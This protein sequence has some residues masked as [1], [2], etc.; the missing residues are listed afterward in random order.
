MK[1]D[2]S[3]FEKAIASLE[4][5]LHLEKTAIIRDSAIQRFEY[6]FEFAVKFMRRYIQENYSV[7]SDYD[8]NN[9]RDVIRT[10]LQLNITKKSFE[11]W[12]KY[13]DARNKTSH[14]YSEKAAEEVYE[15]A[16]EFLV[17]AKL[18]YQFL[19]NHFK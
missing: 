13:R 7:M 6:T 16:Q 10:A 1:I 18:V 19:K 15:V 5:V 4:E 9:F 14:G 12:I 17:E 11:T 3:L 8:S 2:L